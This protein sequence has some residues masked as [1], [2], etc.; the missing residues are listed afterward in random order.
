MATA[1][2][3]QEARTRELRT[4]EVD[5]LPE[6]VDAVLD[7]TQDPPCIYRRREAVDRLPP[8]ELAPLVKL[9]RPREGE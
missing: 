5:D 9:P 1:D 8:I 6:G 7:W 4:T 3:G 2:Q